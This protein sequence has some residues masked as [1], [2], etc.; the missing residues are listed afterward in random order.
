MPD[1]FLFT[2][3]GQVTYFLLKKQGL[4]SIKATNVENVYKEE[5]INE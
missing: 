5:A 3:I 1:M 4:N 2:E